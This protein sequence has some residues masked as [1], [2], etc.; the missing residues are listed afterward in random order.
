MNKAKSAIKD[1]QKELRTFMFRGRL[2][3][4][5][6]LFLMF[7]LLGRMAYLQ[8][9]Q[10]DLY[11]LRSE[12][13]RISFEAIPPTRGLIYDRNGNLLAANQPSY[14]LT[15]TRELSPDYKQVIAKVCELLEQE[16][17]C[18]TEL[19]TRSLQRRPFEPELL[20]DQLTEEQIARLAVNRH[21]LPGIE[22]SAHLL[23]HYPR[24]EAASHAL[25]YV[26]R[27]SE[28]D[29]LTLD[30]AAYS[31]T[32]YLGKTGIERFYEPL[33]HGKVG[34]R[35][36]ETNARGR[37]IQVVE[38]QPPQPGIDLTLHLDAQLQENIYKMFAGRR[39]AA[40]AIEPQTGGLLALVSSPGYDPNIFL[41]LLGATEFNRIAVDPKQPLFDRASRGQYSPGSSIK[42]QMGIAGLDAGVITRDFEIFDRGYYQL[43]NDERLYRNWRRSGHGD[44]NLARAIEVSNNTYFYNL[45]Y[46][47]GID[48]ISSFMERFGFGKSTALDVHA[49]RHG[50]MPSREWKRQ[51]RKEIWFPGE[52]LSTGIGQGYWLVTP[53]QLAT[54]TAHLA[55]KGKWVAPRFLA[56]T[57]PEVTSLGQN[58]DQQTDLNLKDQANWDYM[59][60]AMTQVM[61]GKEGTARFSGLNS[62]YKIA[63]KTG[64]AQV[65][66]LSQDSNVKAKDLPE[67]LKDHAIFVGFAPV[68]NPQIALAIVVEHSGG[69]SQVAAPLAR[70]IFD[71]YLLQQLDI[72]KEP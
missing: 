49:A 2:L 21:L 37:L 60:D 53:L 38:S 24:G 71:S 47:L 3:L 8:V 36:I 6:A 51:T 32:H 67:H 33:L 62:T 43:P 4:V 64:T 20:L 69:G 16:E 25:G 35:K 56:S 14:S 58:S 50:L 22:I 9:F 41:G 52:T 55:N 15:L 66:S 65:Y 7:V 45:A 42:P 5:G 13:N 40:V 26:G 18:Y 61:H 44:V 1:V 29:L 63:G 30:K 19:L 17:T 12:R 31:G 70:E 68:H 27:I 28:D 72:A 10:Y 11:S 39:G 23:R 48:E 54:A 46:L 57:A 34:Y 59:F